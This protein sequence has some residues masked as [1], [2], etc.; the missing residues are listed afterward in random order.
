MKNKF[1]SILIAFTFLSNVYAQKVDLKNEKTTFTILENTSNKI[2]VKSSIDD[3]NFSIVKGKSSVF[4]AISLDGYVTNHNIGSP[5]LPTLNKLIDIPYGASIE[6]NILS[7]TEELIDL[8]N[9][10]INTI[11]PSQPSI[12]KGEDAS[13]APFYYD[14]AIYQSNTFIS[15]EIAKVVSLGKM[16]G[17]QL[18][19]LEICPFQ[20][21]PVTNIL[22][23][24]SDIEFEVNFVGADHALTDLIHSKHN[25]NHFNTSFSQLINSNKSQN[26]DMLTA[27]PVKYVIVSDPSFQAALQPLVEWKTKKGFTVIEAYTNDPAVGNTTASIKAF[28]ENLYNLGTAS[29]PAPSYLLLVGDVA[30]VPSF[31]G[32]TGTHVSDLYYCEYDG[33]GDF[34]PELYYGRFPATSVSEAQNMV[35]KTIEYEQYLFPD[36]SFL[37]HAVMISGVDASMA[38]TYGNGQINYGTGYYIN[39]AHSLASQTYLYP[40]SG[41]SGAQIIQDVNNGASFVNYTA[42]GYGQGWADPSFTC[43]DVYNMTNEHKLP[44]MIG[45]CCQSNMFDDPECFGEALLRVQDRGAIGYIGGSNNTYWN[46]DYWWAV[47]AGSI[48]A[49]PVYNPLNL[50]AYD[51]TFHENGEAAA[52]WHITNA[53]LM[54]AGNLAVTQAGGSEDYYYEIYHLMGDPS[55]MTYFGVPSDMNV[56][57]MA[58]VPIGTSSLNVVAEPDAYVAISMNGVLLDAQLTDASGVVN[59]S[60]PPLSAIG[61]ADVV[62]T[63]QNKQPYIGTVQVINSNSPFVAYDNHINLDATGNNDGLADY[64]ELIILDVSLGNFGMLDANGVTAQLACSNTNVTIIDDADN[65]GTILS[66]DTEMVSSAFSVLIANDILDQ[67][68]INYE[69]IVSDNS[70]N[71]W[72]SYFSMMAHAPLLEIENVTV[73]DPSGNG[74]GRIEAGETVN[75]LIPSNNIGSSS[76]TSLLGT[77]TTS[78]S[79]VSITNSAYSFGS[80]PSVT[81]AVGTFE[82]IVDPNTPFGEV[83]AFTYLLEDGAYSETMTFTELAGIFSEDFETGDY[84]LYNW[85]VI[86]SNPWAIDPNEVYEGSYSSV[87]GNIVDDQ[88]ST[89]EIDIDVLSDGEISFMKKVSSES[90][91]DFLKF[92]IDGQLQGEWSGEVN[93]SAETFFVNAGQH[94]FS[95]VYFKDESVSDGTDAAWVDYILFPPMNSTLSLESQVLFSDLNVYPNPTS[96]SFAVNVISLQNSLVKIAVYDTKGSLVKENAKQVN[97][98]VNSFNFNLNGEAEGMYL[99]NFTDGVNSISR[100]IVIRK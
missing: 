4:S 19:R 45:N 24:I 10:S 38:P 76:C 37:G 87:S 95:W 66:N 98:G 99:I 30:Q 26:K 52:D 96:G 6:I 12:S 100:Q 22:K 13:L 64:G 2:T 92:Y 29:D 89:M 71:S 34:Y 40:A 35:H 80:L 97:S 74:N 3:L 46:E 53:Q 39:L 75:F 82:I 36:P 41:S 48:T 88:L 78:S 68:V 5:D 83:L 23:V 73:D 72:T 14:N 32:V 7:K 84:N 17:H 51:R 63:K 85:N 70:S 49:N 86:S 93:W 15:P 94:T 21:N 28:L 77:L 8:S 33:G 43:A 25:S 31:S 11:T 65:W 59:L 16:R 55:L 20:Y 27:Y 67:E 50:A 69:I 61:T 54:L 56:T 58:A 9:E 44:L 1:C 90:N 81:D 47:G 57:H 91:Y 79:Y 62:V 60:F 18:G 42:H